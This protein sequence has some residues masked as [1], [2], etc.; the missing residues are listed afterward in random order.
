MS[1]APRE[2]A[3]DD[4]PD[5]SRRRW[6]ESGWSAA[7]LYLLA[8][9][10]LAGAGLLPGRV[11]LP[12]DLV[13][14][15]GAWK[16]DPAV[17]VAVSNALLSD[18]ILQ[19]QPWETQARREIS[20]GKFPWTN[21]YAGEGAAIFANPAAGLLSPFTW[22]RLL[23]GDPGW[24]LSVL[25]KLLVAGLGARAFARALGAP[26]LEA[27]ASGLL[28]LASGYSVLWALHPQTNVFAFLP[29]LVASAH[30]LLAAPS[31]R[32][33][34]AVT[35][36]AALATGGG[37]PE[38]LGFGVAAAAAFLA[39][40]LRRMRRESPD[41]VR[42]SR[43]GL[44]SAS[45]AGGF[46][47]AGVQLVPFARIL[48]S[49]RVVDLRSSWPGGGIRWF[50]IV[51]QFLPG[52]LG[53]P[54][55]G[56]I[57]LSG[58]FFG[59]GNLHMRSG[60][61]VGVIALV[62]IALASPRLARPFRASLGVALAALSVAWN[63]PPIGWVWRRLPVARLFAVEYAACAFVLFASVALGP[64]LRVL[65]DRTTRIR[66]VPG[67]LVLAG[68]ALMGAGLLPSLGVSRGPLTETA[69]RGIALLQAR[70]HLRLPAEVY[71]RRLEGYIA[72]SAE[73]T[74]RR[75]ALPGLFW[76]LGGTAL[77][78]RRRRT[79]L[80]AAACFGEV[81]SLGVGYLPAVRRSSVPGSP[82]AI[83][84]VL[85][86]RP[87]TVAMVAA[88]PDV[89]PPDLAT[90]DG[91]RDVRMYEY[92]ET[93]PWADRLRRCGYD[94]IA[95]AFPDRPGPAEAACLGDLGVRYFLGRS[96]VPGAL[97]IGGGEPP[98]V[99][100]YEIRGARAAPPPR[101][102][103]PRGLPA[104]LAASVAGVVVAA[105]AARAAARATARATAE[106]RASQTV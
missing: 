6:T 79:P 40:E 29:W 2:T 49:S 34:L 9:L 81:L 85:A 55:A 11:L 68:A 45:A 56:E 59:S 52:Y 67:A 92:L 36:F 22:L 26:P 57:D 103:P 65:R 88:A 100:A 64:A 78:V 42:V 77:L 30:R 37:H 96:A 19:F 63:L 54:R 61:F 41:G 101:D 27:A 72:A 50:S 53:S 10:A 20:A 87:S 43:E 48:S 24:A 13:R 47:L 17:R 95:R 4:R 75:L 46:L 44:L 33:V 86:T 105:V 69:R 97:R 62:A 94:E 83:E 12:L 70:G 104:G 74:R 89:Y 66:V 58:A 8:G 21:P 14:D 106:S 51:G 73:T 82:P 76:I 15:L 28:Y 71:E 91:I 93:S 90:V 80:L 5:G 25:A 39:L 3:R 32:S 1:R 35:L 31:A 7:L 102:G 16:P 60:A 38:T 84:A 23:L 18:A 99:G 98:A